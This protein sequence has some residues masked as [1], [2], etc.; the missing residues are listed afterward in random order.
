MTEEEQL[1]AIKHWWQR[2][3]NKIT[4]MLSIILLIVA[5]FKYWNWHEDKINQQASNTYEQL[6]VAFS[7]QDNKA[8]RAYANQLT[9]EYGNTVY[10]DVARLTLAKLYATRGKYQQSQDQLSVVAKN[11]KVLSLKQIA[12]IRMVRLLVAEK[13]YDKALSELSQ[14]D[15]VTY[16]PVINELKGD[17]YVA[18]GLYQEAFVAYRQAIVE[19]RTH[20]IGNAFLEMKTN[21]LATLTQSLNNKASQLAS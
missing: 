8:I 2:H 5:G 10:A 11:S 7:N 1:K 17:I 3:N 21:E 13:S 4:I 19:V 12:K 6:M 18:K 16:M 14:V 20:G 15:D 9:K